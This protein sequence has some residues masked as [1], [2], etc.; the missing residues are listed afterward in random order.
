MRPDFPV[1]D[2]SGSATLSGEDCVTEIGPG[3][4][5]VVH[6]STLLS[7]HSKRIVVSI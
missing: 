1:T 4:D 5:W 2:L 7:L 3:L 6:C